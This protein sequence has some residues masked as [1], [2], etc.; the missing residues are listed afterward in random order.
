[1]INRQNMGLLE[2][3]YYYN[4]NPVRRKVFEAVLD[5]YDGD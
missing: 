2:S 5:Y 1:L 3:G 4:V